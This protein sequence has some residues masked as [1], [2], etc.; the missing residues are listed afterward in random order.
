MLSM[1]VHSNVLSFFFFFLTRFHLG[2]RY[3]STLHPSV[4][5]PSLTALHVV[6]ASEVVEEEGVHDGDLPFAYVHPAALLA[7]VVVVEQTTINGHYDFVALRRG[8]LCG[9]RKMGDGGWGRGGGIVR[10]RRGADEGLIG[11]FSSYG[12]PPQT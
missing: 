12:T 5:P 6:T 11:S 4:S 9:V 3:P 7:G 10:G 2:H 1:F 8:D